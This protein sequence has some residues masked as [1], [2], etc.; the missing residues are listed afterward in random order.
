[1][2]GTYYRVDPKPVKAEGYGFKKVS[3]D[4]LADIVNRLSKPTYNSNIEHSERNRT[5]NYRYAK[6]APPPGSP[7]FCSRRI[8][9]GSQSGRSKTKTYS[10][11]DIQRLIRRIRRPTRASTL[12]RRDYYEDAAPSLHSR[13]STA[14]TCTDVTV[15]TASERKKA[16]CQLSRPTTASKGKHAVDCHLC[17]EEDRE[18]NLTPFLPFD[19]PYAPEER[20]V[21]KEEEGSLISRISTH[22]R[23]S[24]K[25]TVPCWKDPPNL[26]PLRVQS[27]HLPLVSGLDRSVSVAHIVERLHTGKG[28]YSRRQRS[29]TQATPVTDF[30]AHM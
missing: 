13:P 29:S 15:I 1:M 21:S 9:V 20:S 14:A 30:D 2:A 19:Y 10:E 26:K 11:Q 24:C 3:Q 12:S 7:S 25:G 18:L 4:E 5:H 16:F 28:N 22:T 8:S 6:S 27:A 23:A 17:T